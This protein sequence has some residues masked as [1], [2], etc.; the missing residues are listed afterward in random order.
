M[1]VPKMNGQTL[2]GKILVAKFA[3]YFVQ[4][5]SLWFDFWLSKFPKFL[6]I[7]IHGTFLAVLVTQMAY[8]S[9]SRNFLST[10]FT[11]YG[12]GFV[13]N[14]SFH[15]FYKGT[16]VGWNC[17]IFNKILTNEKG[18]QPKVSSPKNLI[19]QFSFL[20]IRYIKGC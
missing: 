4:I 15:V 20:S 2:D 14:C 16:L 18:N 11:I 12:Y 10:Q 17:Q 9:V 1:T 6:N 5:G 13:Y 3:F 7:F 8:H 19:L